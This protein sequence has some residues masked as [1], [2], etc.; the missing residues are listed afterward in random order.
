VQPYVPP[1]MLPPQSLQSTCL[2]PCLTP[3]ASHQMPTMMELEQRPGVGKESRT[4]TMPWTKMWQV[5]VG[6]RLVMRLSQS[7]CQGGAT[8]HQGQGQA[9]LQAV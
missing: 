4:V 7:R 8:G 5:L 6:Q 3:T 1:W 9:G 2:P